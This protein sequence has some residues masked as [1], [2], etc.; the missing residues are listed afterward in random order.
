M[1]AFFKEEDYCKSMLAL[2]FS[3]TF[4]NSS[5]NHIKVF[6]LKNSLYIPI[7]QR[8]WLNF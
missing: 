5:D 6:V 3:Y 7:A 8:P 1:Y 4:T 2:S